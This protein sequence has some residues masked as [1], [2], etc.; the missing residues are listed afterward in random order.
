MAEHAAHIATAVFE[1]QTELDRMAEHPEISGTRHGLMTAAA[2]TA[3]LYVLKEEAH[4]IYVAGGKQHN[5]GLMWESTVEFHQGCTHWLSA[6]QAVAEGNIEAAIV[7]TEAS[8]LRFTAATD[9]AA[10]INP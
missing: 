7:Y 10:Q 3:R 9:L 8:E 4:R 2:H 5:D 1:V 6:C